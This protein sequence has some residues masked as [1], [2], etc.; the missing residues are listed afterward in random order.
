VYN[1]AATH[2]GGY[3]LYIHAATRNVHF[4]KEVSSGNLKLRRTI[5]NL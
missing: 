3:N 1:Y 2:F 5:P 4:A